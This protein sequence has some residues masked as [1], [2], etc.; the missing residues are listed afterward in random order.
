MFETNTV[1]IRQILL[2]AQQM[3]A[4]ATLQQ[5]SSPTGILLWSK[6]G[7]VVLGAPVLRETSGISRGGV[8]IK[9][10]TWTHR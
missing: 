9:L 2:S 7:L 4:F 6:N 3:S 8:A 10:L 5:H 1:G